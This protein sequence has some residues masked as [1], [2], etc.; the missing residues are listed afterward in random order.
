MQVD[1]M[2]CGKNFSSFYDATDLMVDFQRSIDY[3]TVHNSIGKVRA[4]EQ[5][6]VKKNDS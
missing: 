6:R 4:H 1:R 5:K 3:W 2:S